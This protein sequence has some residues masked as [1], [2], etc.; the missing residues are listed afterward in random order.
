MIQAPGLKTLVKLFFGVISRLS[1]S[2]RSDVRM[3]HYS[4]LMEQHALKCK[5]LSEYHHLFLLRDI[6]WSRF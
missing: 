6:W 2:S 3:S 1:L 5:Q 4:C